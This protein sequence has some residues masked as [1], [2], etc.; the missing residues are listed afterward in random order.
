MLELLA[1]L[2][3]F[4]WSGDADTGYYQVWLS[5]VES[6]DWCGKPGIFA[7]CYIHDGYTHKIEIAKDRN[8]F[9]RDSY[10][11]NTI[12]DHEYW[13]S[14]RISHGEYPLVGS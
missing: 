8:P 9:E 10:N 2:Y 11:C 1:L 7:A 5:E 14:H 3:P 12:I 13:H 4:L 6:V